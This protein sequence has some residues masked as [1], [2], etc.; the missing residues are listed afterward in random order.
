MADADIRTN[1]FDIDYGFMGALQRAMQMF[2]MGGQ[3][4]G[5]TEAMLFSARPGDVIVT[6]DFREHN[7][8]ERK[9]RS[10]G[11]SGIRVVVV[12]PTREAAG[13]RLS[14]LTGVTHFS[15]D[16]VEAFFR[17]ELG[18]SYATLKYLSKRSL[19]PNRPNYSP[20]DQCREPW[21]EY[22][23]PVSGNTDAQ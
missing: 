23:P 4:S 11:L 19:H 18:E 3:Q 15:H 2:D 5:R 14:S 12:S 20:F 7:W 8:L 9:M 22:H 17:H 16:W 6:K 21:P 1:R 13:R 10:L